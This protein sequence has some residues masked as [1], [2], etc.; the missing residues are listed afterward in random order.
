MIWN[1]LSNLLAMK[2]KENDICRKWRQLKGARERFK[3]QVGA[4]VD[5]VRANI[6]TPSVFYCFYVYMLCYLC[7]SH[8]HLLSSWEGD[9]EKDRKS[10]SEIE[11]L[12]SRRH[13]TD[14]CWLK[15]AALRAYWD[16]NRFDTTLE[17]AA[18]PSVTSASLHL[19]AKLSI[20]TTLCFY[21]SFFELVH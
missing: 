12:A 14:S 13:E 1:A 21:R 20:I 7:Q 15:A 8:S 3:Q 17:T 11:M 6:F 10:G 18:N 5:K 16:A 19:C 4:Y 9:C 2:K